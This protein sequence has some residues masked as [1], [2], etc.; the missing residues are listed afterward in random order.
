MATLARPPYE[1]RT[2]EQFGG[3][4]VVSD[5]QEV[6]WSG[7][8]DLLNVDL[9][10]PG[11]VRAR[12][13][14]A[15]FSTSATSAAIQY[16]VPMVDAFA[17]SR[18][19]ALGLTYLSS[20][21]LATG[22][23]TGPAGS[24]G[25]AVT[26]IT[27]PTLYS[28]DTLGP[29]VVWASDHGTTGEFAKRSDVN[30][31][32]LAV[33]ALLGKPMY[34]CAV[35]TRG[36]GGLSS[37]LAQAGY[38]AA[39]D[40]P[41]GANGGPSTVFFS[42]AG[43]SALA[44]T[45]TNWIKL[46][47]GD[48]ENFTG[49]VAFDGSLYLLKSTKAYQFYSESVQSD[50]GV[51]FNYRTITLPD[52]IPR[53][54]SPTAWQPTAAGPDGV[55]YAGTRGLWRVNSAGVTRVPTPIDAILAGT[56]SSGLAI[57]TVGEIR[58]EWAGPR[59]YIQYALASTAQRLLVWDTTTNTWTLHAYAHTVSALPLHA[60]TYGSS[61]LFGATDGK[62]YK[63]TPATTDDNGTTITWSY[64]SGYAAPADGRRV[65]LRGSSV[66]GY[67]TNAPTLQILTQGGRTNDVADTGS[68]VTL[69]ASPTV[70]E[71]KRRH[72][73]RGVLFAHKLSGTG[74]ATITRLT[75]RFLPPALDY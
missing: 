53:M 33:G 5:P 35:P 73:A 4:N 74:P 42:D 38:F 31:A 37:R 59:L 24:Y 48:G 20:V 62:L 67:S 61:T 69:G 18:F 22:V 52:P 57:G 49:M 34:V 41:S 55:Y 54:T 23:V 72:S 50:G 3:L 51:V 15:V 44:Y 19:A 56:A 14:Y 9:S 28:F 11:R 46:D 45:S 71:G 63:S 68:T 36:A 66:W 8:T 27:R 6:G 25:T 17:G 58:M 29:W 16:A 47:P 30:T 64:T 7:S 21:D 70:A 40:T 43:F 39:A 32:A 13:G 10:Q 60:P 65:K 26:N 75:H 1:E 12:D 2:V